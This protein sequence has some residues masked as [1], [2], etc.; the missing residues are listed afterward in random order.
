[1]A[2]KNHAH[3]S[4]VTLAV[5]TAK[6]GQTIKN[7][8]KT[9]SKNADKFETMDY[10]YVLNDKSI[11]CGVISLKQVFSK[12]EK[13]SRVDD[14]MRKDLVVAHPSTERSTIVYLAL[15]HNLRGIPIVDKDKHFLGVVPYDTILRIFNQE[16]NKDILQFGG[17]FHKMGK[18]LNTIN[19]PSKVMIKSRLP[20]LLMGIIG[21]TIAAFIVTHFEGLLG[22][23]LMLAAFMP[24]LV[25]M[26][27]AVGTQSETL[28]VRSIAIDPRMQIKRYLIREFKIATI[29][30]L[31]CGIL[32][33]GVVTV[34]WKD[35]FV[36]AI[37][38]LAMI[39][40]IFASVLSS[41]LLP[42]VFKKMNLDPAT[43]TGPFA[44]VISDILTLAIY[45]IIAM[46]FLQQFGYL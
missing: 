19:S 35:V 29:L 20:W 7:V 31:I 26:S 39:V 27:D 38:G 46:S 42:L 32:V 8:A 10:V 15:S 44:T 37:V 28:M 36:G 13:N 16:I 1:M 23:S 33:G 6:I 12:L 4:I 43:A 24:I 5:P 14:V 25:Y 30:A 9:L 18:E 3:N 2:K 45:F 41:T 22:K 21:G 17:V 34:F 11:L 40:S